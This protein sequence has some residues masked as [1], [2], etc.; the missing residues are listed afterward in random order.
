MRKVATGKAADYIK[1]QIQLS[2]A[3]FQIIKADCANTTVIPDWLKA[4]APAPAMDIQQ[5]PAVGNA[6]AY[7]V[8]GLN[9]GNKN[10][11]IHTSIQDQIATYAAG[12]ITVDN[13][14]WSAPGTFFAAT[15][16]LIVPAS[17]KDGLKGAAES[18]ADCGGTTPDDANGVPRGCLPCAGMAR[19]ALGSD[20]KSGRCGADNLCT[21]TYSNAASASIAMVLVA[22]MAA[23]AF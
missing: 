4:P 5:T 16:E 17:C 13:Q 23:I 19:C 14:H 8:F 15:D 22:I 18:D 2:G 10:E 7:F 20:C 12:T 3:K 1:Q 21:A 6:N 9:Y 11:E